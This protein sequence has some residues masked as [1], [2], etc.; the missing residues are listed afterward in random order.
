MITL[1]TPILLNNVQ[2]LRYFEDSIIRMRRGRQ[3]RKMRPS[4]GRNCTLRSPARRSFGS[5]AAPRPQRLPRRLPRRRSAKSS[6]V[7]DKFA[8]MCD[9]GNIEIELAAEIGCLT[10]N[11]HK[12]GF[13]DLPG[14][15]AGRPAV[16]RCSLFRRAAGTPGRGWPGQV[17]PKGTKDFPGLPRIFF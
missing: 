5:A 6:L 14:F 12:I 11:M 1:I 15:T 4:K 9:T 13:A 10:L 17:R 2:Y 3:S 8:I 16:T 7:F